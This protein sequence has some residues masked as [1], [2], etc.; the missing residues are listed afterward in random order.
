MLKPVA[1]SNTKN[2]ASWNQ[3]IPKYH[4]YSGTAVSVRT[5][6]PIRNE[7]VV[8]LMRSVGMRKI[9]GRNWGRISASL[10][11]AEN[12][13]LLC[14]GMNAAA[15]GAGKLLRFH[16]GCLPVLFFDCLSRIGQLRRGRTAYEQAL[17][18]GTGLWFRPSRRIE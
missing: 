9:N 14:P 16:F 2:R 1:D 15:M 5:N 10:I 3:S 7:L 12:D 4:R 6:V 8:Q 11:S 18:A 13:V 17:D